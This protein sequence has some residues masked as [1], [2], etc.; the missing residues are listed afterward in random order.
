MKSSVKSFKLA[1]TV[2]ISL[3]L[4]FAKVL[5]IQAAAIATPTRNEQS[6][7]SEQF[8]LD[9]FEDLFPALKDAGNDQY[10]SRQ[11][12]VSMESTEPSPT[13][14]KGIKGAKAQSEGEQGGSVGEGFGAFVLFA[15][16]FFILYSLFF[17]QGSAAAPQ[18]TAKVAAPSQ[19]APEDTV[20]TPDL[21][22]GPADPAVI[23]TPALL[24]GLLG[25]GLKLLRQKKADSQLS[26][27]LEVS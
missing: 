18:P 3:S 24:P 19:G 8:K 15:T 10:K 25:L 14:A 21:A 20:T 11:R 17:R 6:L 7:K 22:G 12:V 1:V 9:Q 13:K 27:E 5:P 4:G 16:I 26:P 23:P 2:A